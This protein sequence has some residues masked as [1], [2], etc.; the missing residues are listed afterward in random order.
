[1]F[2][3]TAEELHRDNLK[4]PSSQVGARIAGEVIGAQGLSRS[5]PSS[6]L[7][8][9]FSPHPANFADFA[10]LCFLCCAVFSLLCGVTAVVY[11]RRQEQSLSSPTSFYCLPSPFFLLRPSCIPR[12]DARLLSERGGDASRSSAPHAGRVLA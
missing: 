10:V 8:L 11:C 4:H 2:S 6:S 1:M 9:D 7:T 3:L 12:R 5:S